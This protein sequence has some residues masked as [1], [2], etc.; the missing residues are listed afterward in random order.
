MLPSALS[1]WIECTPMEKAWNTAIEG[2][3]WDP[4]VTVNYGIFNAA[5]CAAVDFT[6]ALLPW[7][8]IWRLQLRF[9]EKIGVGIA[10]SMGVL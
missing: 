1:T 2:T 9:R 6:L 4:S 10:M 7:H 5:W 3:C 8:L